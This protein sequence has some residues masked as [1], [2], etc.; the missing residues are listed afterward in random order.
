MINF[1]KLLAGTLS[2]AMVLGTMAIP[3]FADESVSESSTVETENSAAD[4]YAGFTDFYEGVK[5]GS[6]KSI[7]A[8]VADGVST[9]GYDVW[10][11]GKA[12]LGNG[13]L[14]DAK[15]GEK[16]GQKLFVVWRYRN[17]SAIP[18]VTKEVKIDGV[19]YQ[20]VIDM[21]L[22]SST[23][24][25][26]FTSQNTTQKAKLETGVTVKG[27]EK[28]FYSNNGLKIIDIP[29]EL[30]SKLNLEKN[31]YWAYFNDASEQYESYTIGSELTGYSSD[32]I[33]L[34]G[35]NTKPR[36]LRY[37]TSANDTYASKNICAWFAIKVDPNGGSCENHTETYTAIESLDSNTTLNLTPTKDGYVFNGWT[38]SNDNI[39]K[40]VTLTAKWAGAHCE[41]DFVEKIIKDS[42]CTEDGSKTLTCSKC[43][44]VETVTIPKKNHVYKEEIIKEATCTDSG[45]KK[46]TCENC[47]STKIETI[48][49]LGHNYENG[50]C[51]R[52]HA[53][54]VM[55]AKIGDK[56]YDTLKEAIS[57]A[58]Y[59]DTVVLLEDIKN[60]KVYE[61]RNKNL[62]FELNGKTINAKCSGS[63]ISIY[64]STVTIKDSVG[65]GAIIQTNGGY[66]SAVFATTGST[67]KIE[68]GKFVSNGQNGAVHTAGSSKCYVSGSVLEGDGGNVAVFEGGSEVQFDNVTLNA[69]FNKTYQMYSDGIWV[70]N[71]SLTIN[72]GI[73]NGSVTARGK[74]SQ[75]S[76]KGGLFSENVIDYVIPGYTTKPDGEMFRVV[77]S[78]AKVID[79]AKT[80]GVEITLND[81]EKHDKINNLEDATYKVVV[82]TASNA[83]IESANAA[84]AKNADDNNNSKQIYDISIIKTDSNGVTTDVSKDITDQKVTLT[85]SE[86]PEENSVKVYHV[87]DSGN[88]ETIENVAQNGNTVTFTASSFSTYAITYNTAADT[89]TITSK[90]GVH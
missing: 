65:N 63:A 72:S 79:T 11:P 45:S 8:I 41:H 20:T 50:E 56:K 3:V 33:V 74:M 90:V 52:C 49:A 82:T 77:K 13:P 32:R 4:D 28:F 54:Q 15:F 78:E 67:L 83:D 89:N 31:L 60:D 29:T 61:I 87:N 37:K 76:I 7:E 66:S 16:D 18:Y 34:Q 85:L 38:I 36:T 27:G 30:V 57:A 81:L 26:F 64:D 23:T 68:N 73:Y 43:N 17:D 1:K 6:I 10:T 55:E 59:G 84:I 71:S 9:D 88:V 39:Y 58:K 2:A 75:I 48:S 19:T 80:A 21:S 40:T 46:L 14:A 42:T 35:A 22:S 5:N 47:Q 70:D 44:T 51:I 69:L 25:G 24:G 62:T 12:E 53:T 86:T